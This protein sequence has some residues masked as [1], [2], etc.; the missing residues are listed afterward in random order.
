MSNKARVDLWNA[1]V[2]QLRYGAAQEEAS[3][4]LAEAVE[5][6]SETGKQAK[7]SFEIT[8]KP[9]G[10]GQYELKEKIKQ[11]LP[12]LPKGTTLMFGTPDGN[13]TRED[14]RQVNMDLRAADDDRPAKFKTA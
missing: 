5:R 2:A 8:V 9:T 1:T 12:D 3:I 13:L 7:V 6:A 11:N 4:M 14:P 10:S